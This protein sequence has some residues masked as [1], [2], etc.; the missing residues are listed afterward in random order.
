MFTL[1]NEMDFGHPSGDAWGMP[2]DLQQKIAQ[3]TAATNQQAA[4]TGQLTDQEISFGAAFD[5]VYAQVQA[6]LLTAAQGMAVLAGEDIQLTSTLSRGVAQMTGSWAQAQAS[7]AEFGT[8]EAQLAVA[9]SLLADAEDALNVENTMLLLAFQ[10]LSAGV[11]VSA[12]SLQAAM[13]AFAEAEQAVAAGATAVIAAESQVN[14]ALIQNETALANETASMRDLA[15]A[16]EMTGIAIADLEAELEAGNYA[17]IEKAAADAKATITSV[18]LA[19]AEA[20]LAAANLTLIGT[21]QRL[22]AGEDVSAESMTAAMAAA[23]AAQADV[24]AL[25]GGLGEVDKAAS[26]A[27]HSMGGLTSLMYGPWFM[28]LYAASYALPMLSGLFSSNAVSAAQFTQAVQ[29]DSLAVGDNTAA[30]IQTTLAKSNLA[31]ISK[32]LGLSQAQLIEYAAGE[33][34]VQQQVAAAYEAKTKALEQSEQASRTTAGRSGANAQD[35]NAQSLSQL[36]AQK[37]ALDAVTTA[38]QQAVEQD[39]AN[40]DALLA[41]EQT[42]QIYTASVNA[43]GSSMLLQTQQTM[44]S[45]QATAEY[46][47]RLLAAQSTQQYMNA[48]VAAGGVNMELQQHATEISNMATVAYGDA[49]MGAYRDQTMLNAALGA[50]YVSMQEQAQTSAISSVGLLNMGQSQGSLNNQLVVAEEAYTQAQQGAGAYNTALTSLNGTTNTLL[51]SEASF[52]TTLNGLTTSVKSNGDSLDVNTV[53]GAANITTI[54]GIATAAQA[55]AVAVYQNDVAT[56]HASTAYQDATNTLAQEKTAFEN[57]ADKAGLNKDKVKQLADELFKLPP[58]V[59]TTV[60]ADVGPAENN[61]AQLLERINTSSGT[62]TVYENSAG[63]VGSTQ[64]QRGGGARASGGPVEQGLLYHVN[65]SG[66][67]GFFVP[68]ANGYV[69]PHDAMAALSSGGSALGPAVGAGSGGGGG[70]GQVTVHVYLNGHEIAAEVRAEAQQYAS[71]NSF[72]GF[73]SLRG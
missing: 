65:E 37:A 4:A 53:K 15:A 11:D 40:S 62:V 72:T 26:G 51:G 68:P 2:A 19:D 69:V 23:K 57:A 58:N 43:L 18:Q 48:A 50:A 56:G 36:E 64:G 47:D 34:D 5:E 41:A 61:L 70:A 35:P 31:G 16:S 20:Q 9:T 54:T 59:T 52:T 45:N 33:K 27:S 12:A 13:T 38:V 21:F 67:E 46:G 8:S 28:A 71:H 39:Q 7:L 24:G 29:Q 6:G 49:L 1:K 25:G 55:A 32:Q 73:E 3:A 30:T 63:T 42:T 44:M 22:A 17:V 10:Q 60:N 66:A 14:L